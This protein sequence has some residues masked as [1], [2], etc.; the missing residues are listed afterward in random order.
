MSLTSSVPK[1]VISNG[2]LS[3]PQLHVKLFVKVS[4][5]EYTGHNNKPTNEGEHT[6]IST[7]F[8]KKTNVLL[9]SK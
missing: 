7:T 9:T 3:Q 4:V 8:V 2:G 1:K 6:I 5:L